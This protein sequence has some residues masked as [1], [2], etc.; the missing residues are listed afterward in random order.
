M[1]KNTSC[2]DIGNYFPLTNIH[3]NTSC[4]D[5]GN[6]FTLT[7]IHKNTSL[8]DISNQVP[9]SSNA[10]YSVFESVKYHTITTGCSY[11]CCYYYLHPSIKIIDFTDLNDD[12]ENRIPISTTQSEFNICLQST[13][14]SV[15]RFSNM[16]FLVSPLRLYLCQP[17]AINT[18]F[19]GL[20][21]LQTTSTSFVLIHLPH[22]C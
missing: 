8:T 22:T 3:K 13:N 1:H 10:I 4:T 15:A 19:D 5:T 18:N 20:R 14:V 7:N 16:I 21:S 6:Y 9:W 2:T 17:I 12:D 11:Y